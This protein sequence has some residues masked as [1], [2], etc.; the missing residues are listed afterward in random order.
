MS[1]NLPK[2]QL[3]LSH[4]VCLRNAEVYRNELANAK[5]PEDSATALGLLT[6][7]NEN[8]DSFKEAYEWLELLGKAQQTSVEPALQILKLMIETAQT[9]LTGFR[10]AGDTDN[11][12][13]VL[14][15]IN[16]YRT[17]INLLIQGGV[18]AET[19]TKTAH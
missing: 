18:V 3:I 15:C 6:Q 19:S 5:T 14:A 8:A 2:E 17:A 1:V 10:A 13:T 11:A 16:S 7:E 4:Q 12:K 9:E